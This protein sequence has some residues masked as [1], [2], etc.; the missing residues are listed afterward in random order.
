MIK[1]IIAALGAS[2]AC[3]LAATANVTFNYGGT[4][5]EI[6]TVTGTFNQYATL[7]ESQPWFI[8]TGAQN[9]IIDSALTAQ[10]AELAPLGFYNQTEYYLPDEDTYPTSP[11][12]DVGAVYAPGTDFIFAV[13]GPAFTSYTP[14]GLP[15]IEPAPWQIATYTIVVTPEP[16]SYVMAAGVGLAM[17]GLCRRAVVKKV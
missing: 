4:D 13:G 12:W 6:G 2:F 11:I 1:T 3:T 7:L 17:F 15:A 8:A 5:Y 14:V 10:A 16:A 9:L